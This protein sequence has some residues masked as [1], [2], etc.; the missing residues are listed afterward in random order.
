MTGL[1]VP[2]GDEPSLAAA[3]VRLLRDP[4]LRAALGRGGRERVEREFSVER[5]VEGTARVYKERRQAG[6]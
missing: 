6:A 2:P 3:I 4:E 1:L 5:L